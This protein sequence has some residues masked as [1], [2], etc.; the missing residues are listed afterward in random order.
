[1]KLECS[2]RSVAAFT[3]VEIALSLAIIGFALVAI[4]GSLPAGLNVQRENREDTIITQDANYLMEAIRSGARG[5]DELTNSVISITNY[6]RNFDTTLNPWSPLAAAGE[7]GYT[8]TSSRVTSIGGVADKSFPLTNGLNII[9]LLSKPKLE[10]V[11]P[12]TVRSNHVVALVRALAGSAS[13]KFPQT[14][15]SVLDLGLTY[16]LVTEVHNLRQDNSSSAQ[17]QRMR[18]NLHEIRLK[19]SWPVFP[20]NKIGN[21]RQTFRVMAGGEYL[22]Q[23]AENGSGQPVFYFHPSA[24]EQ[25]FP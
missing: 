14:N 24:Y 2:H 18:A 9:G 21:G 7:D 20:G 15:A 13:D 6:W 8:T 16:R 12:T 1:M 23:L 3:L 19:F 17:A 25:V 4:I 11:G 5:L 10:S 22:S